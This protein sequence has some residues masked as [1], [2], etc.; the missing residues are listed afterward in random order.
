MQWSVTYIQ[1]LIQGKEVGSGPKN[2]IVPSIKILSLSYA[3]A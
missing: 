3:Q 1:Y 2:Q